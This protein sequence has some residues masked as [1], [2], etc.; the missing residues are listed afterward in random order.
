MD[1]SDGASY[2]GA[3]E[4]GYASGQGTFIDCLGNK[5]VGCFKMSMAHGKGTYTNT[6]GAIYEG[7]WRYDMQH[8]RGV[9]KWT[10][11]NSI[12]TGEFI[13]GL[14]N[15][16]G[17][18][19]HKNKRYEG[20]WK[21]NMMDGQ[22]T[23]EWGYTGPPHNGRSTVKVPAGGMGGL[24]LKK[25]TSSFIPDKASGSLIIGADSQGA[26]ANEK[27]TYTGHWSANKM[28]GFGIFKWASGRLYVGEW[29]S[30]NKDG[31]GILSFKGGNE[32]AGEFVQ[33][34]RQG[35]GYYQWADNRKF[36]G[37]WY[38]NKQHG[39]GVYFSPESTTA[40]FGVW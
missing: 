13:D 16:H 4:L 22:G 20:H 14:R 3:W 17:V 23:M 31:V 5:Y 34:K 10:N 37:W 15:G 9:E 38:E 21:N 25:Q 24:D 18:W 28:D 6:M 33:D 29:A 32:Y 1:W 8:G 2:V 39:L 36:K 40:K 19:L 12:F 7:E 11:S 26:N 35:Y 27:G 30:D